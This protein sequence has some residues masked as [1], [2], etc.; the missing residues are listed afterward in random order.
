MN[1]LTFKDRVTALSKQE[2][3]KIKGGT[4][5]RTDASTSIIIIDIDTA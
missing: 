4:D 3:S 5:T 1:L 2:Q